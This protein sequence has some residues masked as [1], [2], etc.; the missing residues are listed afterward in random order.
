MNAIR[1]IQDPALEG[2]ANMARDEALL[3]QVGTGESPPT[4]RM[5]QWDPPAVSVGYFQH[6]ADFEAL[7][8]PINALAV[9]RRLTGGGAI[10]HDLELTYSL[11]LRR[12]DPLLH[13][14]PN[15]LYELMQDIIIAALAA[16]QIRTRRVAQ[17]H[18][19]G[20]P[21]SSVALSG[22]GMSLS[23]GVQKLGM[24]LRREAVAFRESARPE[25]RGSLERSAVPGEPFF[26]FERR[27]RFDVLYGEAKIAGS[28]Q[29]RTRKAVLQHG[30][31]ILDSRFPQQHVATVP[32][33]FE[34][35]INR[36]RDA[37]VNEFVHLA[38][39]GAG[40]GCWSASELS[41]AATLFDKYAGDGWTRRM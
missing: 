34:D 8:P 23:M 41:T 35:A 24:E 19:A 18:E 2:P 33:P 16:L 39:V 17:G 28:A 21:C 38:S 11:A 36:L 5:Y 25:V 32:I 14:T 37:L 30:S 4:L 1:V 27:H 3:T 31:I 7:G 10:L 15:R 12:E 6:Y 40:S 22:E 20:I 29:R 26:C 9:V 13:Q